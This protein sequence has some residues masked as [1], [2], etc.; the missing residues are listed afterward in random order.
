MHVGEKVGV[1]VR[2]Y[3]SLCRYRCV[4]EKAYACW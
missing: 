4:G 3:M 2:R 1:L